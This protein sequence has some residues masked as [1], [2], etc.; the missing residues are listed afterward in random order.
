MNKG[1]QGMAWSVWEGNEGQAIQAGK[2]R[3]DPTRRGIQRRSCRQ[4]GRKREANK[5]KEGGTDRTSGHT[6]TH[7]SSITGQAGIM[8]GIN[9]QAGKGQGQ[10]GR[11]KVASP[12]I[13]EGR[14]AWAGKYWQH[15]HRHTTRHKREGR[16]ARTTT[17]WQAGR[18]SSPSSFL[19][20]LLLK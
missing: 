17:W 13:Q 8:S 9:R 1:R 14:K 10:Q 6:Q 20:P 12:K 2:G 16:K 15:R 5:P 18:P 19:P 7:T 4:E 11:K 3:Q